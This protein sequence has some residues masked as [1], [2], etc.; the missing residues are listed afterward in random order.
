ME[1]AAITTEDSVTLSEVDEL[2]GE[3]E[4]QFGEQRMLPKAAYPDVMT[5][6]CTTVMSCAC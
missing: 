1:K 4:A 5:K 6:F 2:I 3:L